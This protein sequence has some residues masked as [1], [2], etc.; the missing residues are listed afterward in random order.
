[1]TKMTN[2]TIHVLFLLLI[3][4][5]ALATWKKPPPPEMTQDQSQA[6]EQG[7]HQS[8]ESSAQSASESVSGAESNNSVNIQ[9]QKVEAPVPDLVL[10]P[11]NNTA[12][13]QRVFGFGGARPSGGAV[14]GIPFTSKDCTFEG[15]ADDAFAAGQYAIGYYWDC[16][17][18]PAYKSFRR[19]GASK[20]QAIQACWRRMMELH[21]TVN[22]P[23][24]QPIEVEVDISGEIDADCDHDA[25]HERIFEKCQSK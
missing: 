25:T 16:H 7:Q 12:D 19:A 24:P 22:E 9:G 20:E 11:H 1:M 13:C 18:K 6:Q 5:V 15:D 23:V 21:V 2:K 8:S 14:F 3:P 10:I 17:K 4:C